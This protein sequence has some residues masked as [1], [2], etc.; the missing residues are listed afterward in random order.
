MPRTN[1]PYYNNAAKI[2][3]ILQMQKKTFFLY[4]N[5]LYNELVVANALISI[6]KHIHNSLHVFIGIWDVSAY[7]EQFAHFFAAL[8]NHFFIIGYA[9]FEFQPR[10]H[11]F[12]CKK[13]PFH[14]VA[15]MD[16]AKQCVVGY[17]LYIYQLLPTVTKTVA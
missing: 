6:S 4:S 7:E 13:F 11:H 10:N 16:D 14:T 9:Q 2:Q 15:F 8:P 3:F 17:V 5:G 12:K 1:S